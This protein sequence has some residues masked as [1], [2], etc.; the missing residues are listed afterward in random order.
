LEQVLL[1]PLVPRAQSGSVLALALGLAEAAGA[2][3]VGADV[4]VLWAPAPGL[5]LANTSGW[6]AFSL[7]NKIWA[8]SAIS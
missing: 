5:L 4:L 7:S 2:E 6:S 3:A 8:W 1:E